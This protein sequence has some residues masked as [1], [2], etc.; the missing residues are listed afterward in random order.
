MTVA[1]PP[2]C[3]GQDILTAHLA[4]LGRPIRERKLPSLIALRALK[5]VTAEQI[6]AFNAKM[7]ARPSSAR[8]F[9][10]GRVGR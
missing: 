5:R 1:A 8:A 9:R 2:R 3:C 10:P 6:D 4:A 7:R